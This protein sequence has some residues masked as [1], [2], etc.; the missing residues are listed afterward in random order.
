M[1]ELFENN[2]IEAFEL[3]VGLHELLGHGCGKLFM[4]NKDGTFNF[5]VDKVKH[6]ETGEK[7]A[8]SII[9]LITFLL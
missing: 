8:M 4:K 9:L 1:Q 7:V 2:Y 3:H 5:D 6:L